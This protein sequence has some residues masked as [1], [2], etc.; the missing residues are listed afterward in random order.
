MVYVPVVFFN[1]SNYFF[2]IKELATE[3]KGQFECLGESTEKY[4]RFFFPIE[5]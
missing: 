4:K 1:H 5:K 3:P 2:I